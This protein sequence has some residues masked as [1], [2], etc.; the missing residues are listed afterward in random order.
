MSHCK[1]KRKFQTAWPP[2]P[3]FTSR[4]EQGPDQCDAHHYVTKEATREFLG[5][6]SEIHKDTI[7]VTTSPPAVESNWSYISVTTV[8]ESHT[9][10]VTLKQ[11]LPCIPSDVVDFFSDAGI[12]GVS[13]ARNAACNLLYWQLND[14]WSRNLYCIDIKGFTTMHLHPKF[15]KLLFE[16]T[17]IV[18]SFL[19]SKKKNFQLC[20]CNEH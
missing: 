7:R 9:W 1:L 2:T 16:S 18:E 14:K 10:W 4:A 12:M 11:A 8:K 3:D 15:L 5:A 20:I 6:R 13:E 19:S 17:F